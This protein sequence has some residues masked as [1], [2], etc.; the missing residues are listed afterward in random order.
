M[1]A[2]VCV[3]RK[4]LRHRDRVRL[5]LATVASDNDYGD[6]YGGRWGGG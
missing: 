3:C 2:G 4:A 6:D 5:M 1:H